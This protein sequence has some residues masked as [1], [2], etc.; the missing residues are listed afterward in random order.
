MSYTKSEGTYKWQPYSVTPNKWSQIFSPTSGKCRK[1]T[2][3]SGYLVTK[4]QKSNSARWSCAM[5]INLSALEAPRC[6]GIHRTKDHRDWAPWSWA[7]THNVPQSDVFVQKATVFSAQDHGYVDTLR[8]IA[9]DHGAQSRWSF[10]LW[11][12]SASSH[13]VLN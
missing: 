8:V 9:H 2:H 10:V 12:P 1:G 7:M 4:N 6:L 5:D 11:L 13:K 3:K